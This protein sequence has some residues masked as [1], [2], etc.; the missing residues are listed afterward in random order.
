MTEAPAY[1]QASSTIRRIHG[2]RA[3]AISGA[4]ALLMQ[5]AHPLA[6]F[7]LLSHSSALEEPYDRLGRTAEA[8]NAIVF[9]TREQ[10]DAVSRR[11]R[12]MHRRV[13]GRLPSAIGPYPA[14]TPYRADDP[15]LLMWILYTL[16]D[17][18]MVLYA[19]YVRPLA[20]AERESFWQD[21]R[22]VGRLFGLRAAEM[23]ATSAELADYGREMLDSGRLVVTDWARERARQIVLSPPVPTLAQPALQTVNFVTIALLP[24]EIRRQYR[25]SPL[26]PPL[27]RRALVAGG[28]EYFRRAVLPFIP[29]RLRLVPG[30]RAAA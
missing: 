8:M 27:L 15:E 24:D 19:R 26:P 30:A 9:G 21:Y 14:G 1:F 4:R 2:E 28:A 12:A 3:V 6:V 17:S 25:F 5:A 10:A 23:P 20:A 29:G 13:S 7:G 16:V 11:V 18:A 22:V